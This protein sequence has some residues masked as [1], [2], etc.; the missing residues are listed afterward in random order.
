M[1]IR[2]LKVPP[3]CTLD[4]SG[5]LRLPRS[6]YV[7]VRFYVCETDKKDTKAGALLETRSFRTNDPD[8]DAVIIAADYAR[9]T[10]KAAYM[11]FVEEH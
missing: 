3:E 11:E 8:K 6:S 4:G 1:G 9:A 2:L 10:Y 5:V 7:R